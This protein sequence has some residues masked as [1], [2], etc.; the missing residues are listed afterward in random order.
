MIFC[1]LKKKNDSN[2]IYLNFINKKQ[3]RFLINKLI[4]I[5]RNIFKTKIQIL[6]I[7]INK[8]S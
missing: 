6:F 1:L 4:Y 8:I 2:N 5:L 3:K 7:K